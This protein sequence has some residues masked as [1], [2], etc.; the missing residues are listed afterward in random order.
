MS[1][2]LK[3]AMPLEWRVRS[4]NDCETAIWRLSCGCHVKLTLGPW[5]RRLSMDDR[6]AVQEP[7]K[8]DLRIDVDE[9][10]ALIRYFDCTGV[11]ARER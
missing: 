7:E 1:F 11:A 9:S 2:V 8:E 5:I 3:R 6:G 4:A 10:G